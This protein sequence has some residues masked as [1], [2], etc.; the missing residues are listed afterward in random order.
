MPKVSE[1]LLKMSESM[2]EL[3]QRAKDAEERTAKARAENRGNERLRSLR[4]GPMRNAVARSSLHVGPKR[5]MMSPRA[6][7]T[8][9]HT[10]RSMARRCAPR[11]MRNVASTT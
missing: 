1:S 7:P 3:S 8:F 11:S 10:F 9:V 6:G 2:A 5:R 4:Q